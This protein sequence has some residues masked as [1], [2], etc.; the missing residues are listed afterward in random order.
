M[1]NWDR[2]VIFRSVDWLCREGGLSLEE[3]LQKNG[4]HVA[5]LISVYIYQSQGPIP[6]D[7]LDFKLN[8]I[9]ERSRGNEH[10]KIKIVR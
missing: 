2:A 6:P 8:S 7:D 1:Y 4:I 9:K 3:E 10:L 5:E